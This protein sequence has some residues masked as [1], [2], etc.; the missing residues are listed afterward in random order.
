MV[1]RNLA[2]AGMVS[3]IGCVTVTIVV[4]AL[5]AGLWLDKMLE[6][7]PVMTIVCLLFSIPVSMYSLVRVALAT[8][9]Q[10]QV[11][12]PSSSNKQ[13]QAETIREGEGE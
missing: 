13:E 7:R 10:F 2:L 9:A 5:L 8:A 4:G 12:A 3:Q 1:V 6:T 11:P